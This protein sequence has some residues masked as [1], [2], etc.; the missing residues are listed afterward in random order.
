M[1]EVRERLHEDVELLNAE[2]LKDSWELAQQKRKLNDRN[3]TKAAQKETM[4]ARQ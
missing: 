4:E 1:K 3:L 2:I